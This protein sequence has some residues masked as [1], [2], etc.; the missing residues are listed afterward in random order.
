MEAIHSE[1]FRHILEFWIGDTA[2]FILSEVARW[3]SDCMQEILQAALEPAGPW[4]SSNTMGEA[5][6]LC[7]GDWETNRSEHFRKLL[8]GCRLLNRTDFSMVIELYIQRQSLLRRSNFCAAK[9]I[10]TQLDSVA[11]NLHRPFSNA[12]Y[13]AIFRHMT[14]AHCQRSVAARVNKAWFAGT[15]AMLQE[16]LTAWEAEHAR[17][18]LATFHRL[19]WLCPA[20]HWQISRS[21]TNDCLFRL[22]LPGHIA[23]CRLPK[24]IAEVIPI[25]R[26][27]IRWTGRTLL[28]SRGPRSTW[29]I[30]L[31]SNPATSWRDNNMMQRLTGQR[32]EI[33]LSPRATED[34]IQETLHLLQSLHLSQICLES[35]AKLDYLLRHK[36][37]KA[38]IGPGR[39]PTLFTWCCV[40]HGQLG[41]L[42]NDLCAA[43]HGTWTEEQWHSISL[44]VI[45]ALLVAE[46]ILQQPGEFVNIIS[47]A[48]GWATQSATPKTVLQQLG[49]E[50]ASI[51][52]W[53][54]ITTEVGG[55][56]NILATIRDLQRKI[57]VVTLAIDSAA[58]LLWHSTNEACPDWQAWAALRATSKSIAFVLPNPGHYNRIQIYGMSSTQGRQ[59]LFVINDNIRLP[60]TGWND[61][62]AAHIAEFH[63]RHR[64]GCH[65]ELQCY[66]SVQWLARASLGQLRQLRIIILLGCECFTN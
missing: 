14:M 16:P 52:F 25:L 40:R 55:G 5:V 60:L 57:Q 44:R 62:V 26:G 63:H 22:L 15:D 41:H 48:E 6:A 3:T 11:R 21:T 32:L 27:H 61:F 31:G 54:Y 47:G 42:L 51:R 23:P 59:Q 38:L 37:T 35:V 7:M 24:R 13:I 66:P 49:R 4:R 64:R 30:A 50:V 46:F 10:T 1:I 65:L 18:G 43:I 28:Y 12:E 58:R 53:L 19:P 34:Q 29:T 9:R 56:R 17:L 36:V 33:E 45:V 2:Q 20:P 8:H 39:L